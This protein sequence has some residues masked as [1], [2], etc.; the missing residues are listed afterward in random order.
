MEAGTEL[1]FLH[2]CYLTCDEIHRCCVYVSNFWN[3]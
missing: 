1:C 3:R 2:F